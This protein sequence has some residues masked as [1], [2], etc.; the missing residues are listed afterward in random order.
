MHNN[1]ALIVVVAPPN[2]VPQV[3]GG[4]GAGSFLRTALGLLPGP[5]AWLGWQ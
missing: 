5:R 4:M 1:A 3:V 2:S